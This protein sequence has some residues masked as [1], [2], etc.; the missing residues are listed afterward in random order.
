MCGG[1]LVSRKQPTCDE[2]VQPVWCSVP[3]IMEDGG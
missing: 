3:T 1:C 2:L